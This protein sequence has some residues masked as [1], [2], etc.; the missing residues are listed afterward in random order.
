VIDGGQVEIRFETG[1]PSEQVLEFVSAFDTATFFH[2]PAW[3]EILAESFPRFD[4]GWITARDGGEL[5]GLMPVVKTVRGPAFMVFSLP[6]GTYGDPLA[7][8]PDV[9]SAVF[10]FFISMASST[11]CARAGANLVSYRQGLDL[12]RGWKTKM[13]EC[14]IIIL[15]DTFEEYRSRGMSRKRRQLCN[16]CEREGVVARRLE[17]DEDFDLFYNIYLHGASGWG[18]VHP[19][20]RIFFESLFRRDSEGVCFWGAFHDRE[21]LAA[22]VDFYFG[23]TAQAWQAGVSPQASEHDT[24]AYLLMIAVNEAILRGVSVFNLGSS[25]GDAGMIFFKESMGGEEHLYP[26]VEKKRRLLEWLRRR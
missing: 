22:H 12:P 21:L 10:D 23:R 26:V 13:E 18:G 14:R 4:C 3:L 6:F 5:A 11:R 9:R 24:A 17:G 2:S 16:R 25:G 19:Y 20:P 8:D 1:I 7:V 15:P